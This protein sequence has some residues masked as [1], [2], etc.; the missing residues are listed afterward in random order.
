MLRIPW[1]DLTL[2]EPCGG[3]TYGAVFRAIWRPSLSQ[4][5]TSKLDHASQGGDATS[6]GGPEKR[7]RER[8]VAVKRVLQLGAEAEVLAR[9]SH[10]HIVQFLGVVDEPAN[11]AIVMGTRFHFVFDASHALLLLIAVI[12]YLS[13]YL[14][15]LLPRLRPPR[16]T[17]SPIFALNSL[18]L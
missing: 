6:S 3:G 4:T 12:D 7:T 9:L 15:F 8:P 2:Y 11:F 16:L 13:P 5:T 10:R 14:D 1:N 17:H 18:Y